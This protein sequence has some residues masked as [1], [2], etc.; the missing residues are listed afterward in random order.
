MHNQKILFIFATVVFAG[1]FGVITAALALDVK[2]LRFGQHGAS[3]RIVMDLDKEADFR[4]ALEDSPPRIVI[5]LPAI[6]DRPELSLKDLPPLIR[7]VR[8]E[9]IDPNHSRLSFILSRTA[10]IRGAFMIPASGREGARLVVDAAPAA[11]PAFE[12]QIGR[13]YGNLTVASAPTPTTTPGRNLPFA[14]IAKPQLDPISKPTSPDVSA[15][16]APQ[17]ANERPLVVI[18]PGHGGVDGGASGFGVIEKNVTFAVA[19]DLRDA[20]EKSGKYRVALTRESDIFIP[21]GQRVRIAR[22]KGADLFV[23]IHAD[24]MPGTSA[25][26]GASFYTLSD[27]AS[28]AQTARLAARENQADLLAGIQLPSQDKEVAT[29]LIDLAM[30][31]TTT[32]SKRV[33]SLLITAFKKADMPL[34]P[35][36]D[37][38]AGFMVLKAPDVPS[39]L[40][41]LGFLSTPG[42][43]R[44]LDDSGYRKDLAR[45]LAD[46]IDTWF[47]TRRNP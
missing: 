23:S 19:K 31:E 22:S 6:T 20:L 30:R 34:V 32:Q 4:A 2:T 47:K 29:I 41:E 40:V 36:P 7:D 9:T 12:Q 46:G 18:D 13:P 17:I 25:A 39:V 10:A 11:Q 44:K 42:E 38:H 8:I 15:P 27:Q 35:G 33:S 21:L 5:D 16:A 24:A 1:F 45:T 3:T 28:D 43:A 37:R 26:K 14:G